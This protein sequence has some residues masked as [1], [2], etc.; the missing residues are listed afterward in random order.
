MRLVQQ[1]ATK[2]QNLIKICDIRIHTAA[3]V[4]ILQQVEHAQVRG[5]L[6]TYRW[7][8]TMLV[9][10]NEQFLLLSHNSKHVCFLENAT[11]ISIV[12]HT[13]LCSSCN[14]NIFLRFHQST[15]SDLFVTITNARV[16]VLP[17]KP[18][19]HT[20]SLSHSLFLVHANTCQEHM[21]CIDTHA[22]RMSYALVGSFETHSRQNL[23]E[24]ES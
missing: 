3:C 1:I 21:Q 11:T 2:I 8:R 23:S 15:E 19:M 13:S 10:H 24:P 12:Q 16:H 14:Q 7:R 17:L 4:S 22:G 9:L 18:S 5:R 6:Y 20:K